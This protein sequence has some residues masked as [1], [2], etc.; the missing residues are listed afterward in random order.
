MERSIGRICEPMHGEHQAWS[1][2]VHT[3][4]SVFKDLGQ[5]QTQ[6]VAHPQLQIIS[7]PQAL[8]GGSQASPAA[9]LGSYGKTE[10]IS[11]IAI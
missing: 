11:P 10:E 2:A 1:T 4:L 6:A 5:S 7:R 3:P 8:Q 9:S